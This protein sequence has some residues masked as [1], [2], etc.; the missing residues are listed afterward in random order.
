MGPALQHLL[1]G[2]TLNVA[3]LTAALIA[4]R[5]LPIVVLAPWFGGEAIPT[6][7][8]IGIGVTLVILLFPL[9]GHE[10]PPGDAL[11]YIALLVKELGVGVVIAY[12]TG[13][14]F[15]AVRAG[16]SLIDTAG[17]ANLATAMVPEIHEQASLFAN[18]QLQLA[19]VLFFVVGGHRY[20][21]AAIFA[22]FDAVPLM[23]FP[24]MSRGA[25]PLVELVMRLGA[26]VLTVGFTIAAPTLAAIFL[27]DVTFGLLNRV[28]PTINVYFMSL[29]VKLTLAAA[30]VLLGLTVLTGVMREGFAH[31]ID[32]LNET[33]ELLR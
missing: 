31:M 27:S 5:V 11:H 12:V 3:I 14:I 15:E 6:Q 1:G 32:R 22:S 13:V 24:A 28:A 9:V 18:L 23:H 20:A 33:I 25:W 30:V 26:D 17:G 29:P 2:N 19:V 8:R 4:A 16:G 10:L 21:F 7:I